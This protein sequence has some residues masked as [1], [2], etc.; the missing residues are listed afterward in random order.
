MNSNVGRMAA[1]PGKRTGRQGGL[2]R[3]GWMTDPELSAAGRGRRGRRETLRQRE[4]RIGRIYNAN[5]VVKALLDVELLR[6]VT[7]LWHSVF[8][9][10]A[11]GAF[12]IPSEEN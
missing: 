3:G 10:F 2:S 7:L 6:S 8:V 9:V 4:R 1:G 11:G 12:C 5:A